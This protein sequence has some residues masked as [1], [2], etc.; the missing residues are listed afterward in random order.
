MMHGQKNSVTA[1][2]QYLITS[3][4][5]TVYTCTRASP[6]RCIRYIV[7]RPWLPTCAHSQEEI[8]LLQNPK[9]RSCEM[10]TDFEFFPPRPHM[11]HSL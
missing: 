9:I 4:G 3:Y 1:K 6:P 7:L 11:L 8:S 2:F 10:I 5:N